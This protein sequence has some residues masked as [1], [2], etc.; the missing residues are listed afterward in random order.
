[1][2]SYESQN[3]NWYEFKNEKEKADEKTNIIGGKTSD[4]LSIVSLLKVFDSLVS[5]AAGVAKA[6]DDNKAT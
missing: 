3:E 6:I 4:V 1:L 5:G 2:N